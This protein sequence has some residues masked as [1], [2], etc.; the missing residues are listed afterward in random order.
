MPTCHG[1]CVGAISKEDYRELID[2]VVEFLSGD[3]RPIRRA[4][5]EQ[6]RL[7]ASE[8][9][10]E[11]AARYRNRLQAIERLSERQGVERRSI[12]T[13]DVLGIAVSAGN[14]GTNGVASNYYPVFDSIES[15]AIAPS[16]I[17][18]G[19]RAPPSSS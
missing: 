14:Y 18:V 16:V 3:D 8:E 6:M 9:R 4:L 17:S 11:D 2:Q 7:A 13:I 19:A 1:P 10:F 15:P 5:D 12:G